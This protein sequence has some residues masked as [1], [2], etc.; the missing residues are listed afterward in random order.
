MGHAINPG[1]SLLTN[2]PGCLRS[3]AGFACALVLLASAHAV[4][5]FTFRSGQLKNEPLK[6]EKTIK[7]QRLTAYRPEVAA[8]HRKT[9][10]E[11]P[12]TY[13]RKH[14]G[15]QKPSLRSAPFRD[16]GRGGGRPIRVQD[17]WDALKLAKDRRLLPDRRGRSY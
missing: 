6:E 3:L 14:E 15:N 5:P 9:P 7:G 13:G 10:K 1:V 2:A 16:A 11:M 8:I 4:A 17:R 12:A